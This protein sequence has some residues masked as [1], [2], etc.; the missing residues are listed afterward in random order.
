[1]RWCLHNIRHK[2]QPSK[3][4]TFNVPYDLSSLLARFVLRKLIRPAVASPLNRWWKVQGYYCGWSM[5]IGPSILFA[6]VSPSPKRT[7]TL[8]YPPHCQSSFKLAGY[9]EMVVNNP[10]AV[11]NRR[12]A[13][14]KLRRSSCTRLTV[15][16]LFFVQGLTPST[17]VSGL[18]VTIGQSSAIHWF[19]LQWPRVLQNY[20]FP[21][22]PQLS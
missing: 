2:K 13:Q 19:F 18:S 5:L 7:H 11:N 21:N 3:M 8:R 20:T 16:F 12:T 6:A 17:Q 10:P 4:V 15:T 9:Y 1:M 14:N 22:W